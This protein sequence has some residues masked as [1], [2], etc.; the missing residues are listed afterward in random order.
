MNTLGKIPNKSVEKQ[1][2]KT[3]VHGGHKLISAIKNISMFISIIKQETKKCL[4]NRKDP[5]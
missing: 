1:I 5:R 2:P 4:N 3:W